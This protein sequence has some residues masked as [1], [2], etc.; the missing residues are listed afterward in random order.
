M[1][2]STSPDAGLRYY[3]GWQS[4]PFMLPRLKQCFAYAPGDDRAAGYL[5][6]EGGQ[7]WPE[8]F[9]HDG[10]RLLDDLAARVG[11]KFTIVLYQAYLKGSGC[12]W[13]SDDSFD[14][15]AILSMGVTRTFA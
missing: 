10:G 1:R 2:S 15:Q 8:V 9:A 4:C 7:A 3:H 13:H 11:I 5:F 12:G 14:V 6:T